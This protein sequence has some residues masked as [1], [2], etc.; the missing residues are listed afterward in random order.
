MHC[1]NILKL[2]RTIFLYFDTLHALWNQISRE[3]FMIVIVIAQILYDTVTIEV[4]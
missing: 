4:W 3:L 2:I 1:D